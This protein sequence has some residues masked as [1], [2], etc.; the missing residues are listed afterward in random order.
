MKKRPTV[1]KKEKE[2]PPTG[3]VFVFPGS[4]GWEVWSVENGGARCVGPAENPQK[5]KAPEGS[6]ICLPSRSIFSVPL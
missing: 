4:E 6:V 5:L 3:P 2:N 1:A